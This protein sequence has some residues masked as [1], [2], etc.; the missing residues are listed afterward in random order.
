M[1]EIGE[2][3]KGEVVG[4]E[5]QERKQKSFQSTQMTSLVIACGL[6]PPFSLNV[7]SNDRRLSV[8]PWISWW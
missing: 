1:V 8:A 5:K 3:G 6:V 4:V 7:P 2:S